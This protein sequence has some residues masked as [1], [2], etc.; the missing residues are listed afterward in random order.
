MTS[1]DYTLKRDTYRGLTTL[2]ELFCPLDNHL[3]YTLEDCV[4][5][6]GI[7]DKKRT[8]IPATGNGM[9]KYRLS[10]SY[11]QKFKRILPIIYT[12]TDKQTLEAAGIS[13]VGVRMHGANDS[14]DVEGC[15]GVAESRIPDAELDKLAEKSK[16]DVNAAW[17]IRNC[18]PALQRIIY[19]IMSYENKGIA[20]YLTVYN[21]AQK[22]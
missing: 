14:E 20:C 5:G 4:R 7:K 18:E 17:M 12:S 8:A 2:G 3:A 21:L 6:W 22:S 16:G 1:V 10:L 15:V 19:S 11:S 9:I 13:F